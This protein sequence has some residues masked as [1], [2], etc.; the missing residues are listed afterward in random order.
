MHLREARS[1]DRMHATPF[2]SGM[3]RQLERQWQ[4]HEGALP[5]NL[6]A[7]YTRVSAG[8]TRER[9]DSCGAARL[10]ARRVVYSVGR[11]KNPG[12]WTGLRR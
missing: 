11:Y 4:W 5:G 8:R 3:Q 9:A 7:D 2:A 1:K 10:G 12:N 6:L